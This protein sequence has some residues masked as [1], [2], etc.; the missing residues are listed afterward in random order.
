MAV[1]CTA[2]RDVTMRWGGG[3]DTL[4]WGDGDDGHAIARGTGAG[5]AATTAA[6]FFGGCRA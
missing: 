2:A 5:R 3:R 4:R 1:R 6:G